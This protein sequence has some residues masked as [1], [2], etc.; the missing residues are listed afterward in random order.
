M[1]GQYEGAWRGGDWARD[2]STGPT[3]FNAGLYA[4]LRCATLRPVPCVRRISYRPA[5]RLR[6]GGRGA[7]DVLEP[8]RAAEVAALAAMGG[9]AAPCAVWAH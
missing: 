9:C 6:G 1:A 2:E 3:A 5:R 8:V 7:A 4:A